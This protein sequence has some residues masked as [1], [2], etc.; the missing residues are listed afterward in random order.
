MAAASFA[1]VGG[2]PLGCAPAKL[3]VDTPSVG[4]AT[5]SVAQAQSV[6]ASPHKSAHLD[7]R[8]GRVEVA[9][10]DAGGTAD[11]SALIRRPQSERQ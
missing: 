7:H 10:Q 1:L 4:G 5:S 3:V 11:T 6:A 2:L 9:L 8:G